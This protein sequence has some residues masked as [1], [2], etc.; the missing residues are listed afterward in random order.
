MYASRQ[1]LAAAEKVFALA[2]LSLVLMIIAFVF[3]SSPLLIFFSLPS[4][5]HLITSIFATL[6]W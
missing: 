6:C 3:I 4:F 2:A 5:L 1:Q